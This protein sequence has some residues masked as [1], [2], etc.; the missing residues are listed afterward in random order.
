MYAG[1]GPARSL[2]QRGFTDKATEG[3]LQLAL[4]GGFAGLNLPSSEVGAVVGKGELPSLRGL[5]LRLSLGL[6]RHGLCGFC[7]GNQCR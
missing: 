7:H 3:G 1:V 4:Y 2:G 6:L 5:G